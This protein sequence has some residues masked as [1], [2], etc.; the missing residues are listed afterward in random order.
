[1]SFD[2]RP[3]SELVA[4]PPSEW[5]CGHRRQEEKMT[6]PYGLSLGGLLVREFQVNTDECRW[7]DGLVLHTNGAGD[8]YPT[9]VI[10]G[11]CLGDPRRSALNSYVRGSDAT[12][13]QT[14]LKTLGAVLLGQTLFG[15]L[16]LSLTPWAPA[17]ISLVSLCTAHEP[18]LERLLTSIPGCEGLR[19]EIGSLA[20]AGGFLAGV[21]SRSRPN[22]QIV[23]DLELRQE[24]E[25]ALG[26]GSPT[27]QLRLDSGETAEAIYET[28][29]GLLC[30]HAV[31]RPVSLA[32]AGLVLFLGEVL[33]ARHPEAHVRS[34][35]VTTKPDAVVTRLLRRYARCDALRPD[36]R[37]W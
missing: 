4:E 31:P 11:K 12:V 2:P 22:R 32:L 36:G 34:V 28:E 9:G 1:M 3:L 20:D 14:K 16:A 24:A 15:G 25:A 8:P 37:R 19:V 17:R 6:D 35:G 23:S 10:C 5:N 27:H 7:L 13:I 30:L 33:A 26:L 21:E 29:D 18:E